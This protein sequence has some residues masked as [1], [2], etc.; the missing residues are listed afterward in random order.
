[1]G[2]LTLHR[3]VRLTLAAI[4]CIFICTSLVQA[5]VHVM[6]IAGVS[7]DEDQAVIYSKEV[8]GW[9]KLLAA[10]EISED[11]VEVIQQPT[12]RPVEGPSVRDQIRAR[13]AALNQS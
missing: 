1:M 6:L 12:Q 9:Q 10:V 7:G 3:R 8:Q 13:F 2:V 5:R 4:S 11:Q